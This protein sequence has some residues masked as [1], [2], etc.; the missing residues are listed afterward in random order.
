[1]RAATAVLFGLALGACSSGTQD[2]PGIG[3]IALDMARA[4]ISG[5]TETAEAQPTPKVTRAQM[6]ALGRPVIHVAIPRLGSGLPAVEIAR[7]RGFRTYMGADQASFTL[8]DGIVTATRGLPVDLIAQDLSHPPRTLF[9]G[10]FPKTYTRTQRHL[11]GGGA[12]RSDEYACAIAPAPDPSRIDIFGRS[13][14]TREFTELCRNTTRAF[15]NSYW[16][17]AAGIVWQS[18]QSVSKDVGHIIVQRVIR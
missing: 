7:N 14:D 9:S 3:K 2:Q 15:K 12:L 16:V 18:H 6:A 1:M 11:T 8:Q 13:H 17:D 10:S 4:R 5:G